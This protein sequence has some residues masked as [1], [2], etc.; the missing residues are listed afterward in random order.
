QSANT[1]T[2][3]LSL[4]DALP[5]SEQAIA[6]VQAENHKGIAGIIDYLG[7]DVSSEQDAARVAD[8]YV[9]VLALIHRHRCQC[10]ISLKV[11]QMGL[12]SEEHTSELQSPDHLV[13]R[14]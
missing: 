14:L 10:A 9:K 6:V 3:T 1:A 13:C 2:Y 4:H 12:R 5:I 11:S 7:E 8:E